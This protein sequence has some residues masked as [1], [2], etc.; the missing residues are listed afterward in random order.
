MNKVIRIVSAWLVIGLLLI[1]NE[2]PFDIKLFVNDC[3][4]VYRF[5]ARYI[6]V[7]DDIMKYSHEDE[8]R[9]WQL[10]D[11]KEIHLKQTGERKT[12][13]RKIDGQ[14]EEVKYPSCNLQI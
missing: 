13:L 2:S 3:Q 9:T 4:Q 1:G 10:H 14:F 8:L 12:I 11:I 5:D 7:E 6:Y